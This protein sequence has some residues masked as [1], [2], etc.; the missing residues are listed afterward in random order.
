MPRAIK[1]VLTQTYT[2]I[3]VIIIDDG[4]TDETP[5]IIFA[6]PTVHYYYQQN[7]GIAAARNNGIK[8]SSGKYLIFLDADDWLLPDAVENNLA[9]IGQNTDIAFVSGNY[10]LFRAETGVLEE[11]S[12]L[13]SEHH[14]VEM[15]QR[16]YIGMIA[17]VMFAKWV[18]E[19]IQ[20]DERL[21][22]CEDYD[23]FLRITRQFPVVHHQK[24]IATYYFHK[25][26]LSHNYNNMM[27]TIKIVMGKQ[28]DFVQNPQ[29]KIA[30]QI[31]MQQWKD[32]HLMISDNLKQD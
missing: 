9:V 31:G 18:F 4:S 17:T 25:N 11:V 20:Y 8:N 15:L 29:E 22:A 1:S 7:K 3:E 28:L 23:L 16:N 24:T 6:Y 14:Y 21:S 13:V 30:Y 26:G 2:N 27:N 12:V 32:Y 19:N 5:S 10:F